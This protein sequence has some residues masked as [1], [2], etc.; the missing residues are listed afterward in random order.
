MALKV[1]QYKIEKIT[2][3]KKTFQ[4]SISIVVHVYL[5]LERQSSYIQ[6]F[7]DHL[8]LDKL[9][10]EPECRIDLHS[11]SLTRL[12]IFPTITKPNRD[13]SREAP[14]SGWGVLMAMPTKAVRTQLRAC[15]VEVLLFIGRN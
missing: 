1:I 2:R 11:L 6:Q 4:K 3:Q 15:V 12:K 9:E 14:I 8:G 10:S 5:E 13:K 7:P